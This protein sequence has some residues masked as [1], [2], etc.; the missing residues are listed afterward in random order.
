MLEGTLK[1]RLWS[2]LVNCSRVNSTSVAHDIQTRTIS[3]AAKP[4][5]RS[6]TYQSGFFFTTR[7]IDPIAIEI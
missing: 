5:S 4:A 6:D 3:A 2:G 7:Q 1:L